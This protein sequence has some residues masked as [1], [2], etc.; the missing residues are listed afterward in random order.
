MRRVMERAMLSVIA[1]Q[2]GLA[3]DDPRVRHVFERESRLMAGGGAA[4]AV[5]RKNATS[6]GVVIS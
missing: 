4:P 3:E 6:A 2:M 1:A 5:E